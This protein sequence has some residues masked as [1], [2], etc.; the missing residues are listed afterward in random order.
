MQSAQPP[1]FKLDMMST[2]TWRL[3]FH[4][5]HE[6]AQMRRCGHTRQLSVST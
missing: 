3:L 1:G 4:C 2:N 6:L 5:I